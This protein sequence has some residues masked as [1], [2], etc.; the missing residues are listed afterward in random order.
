MFTTKSKVPDTPGPNVQKQ[1]KAA[2]RKIIIGNLGFEVIIH[3]I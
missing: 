3:D 1:T 2:K